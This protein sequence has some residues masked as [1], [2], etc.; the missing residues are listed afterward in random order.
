MMEY[1]YS[2]QLSPSSVETEGLCEGLSIRK[3]VVE[4][5]RAL[6][7]PLVHYKDSLGPE[8]SFMAVSMPEYLSD[9]FEIWSYANEFAFL[10]GS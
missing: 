8:H 9:R 10:H 5:W 7:A 6:V 2:H 1:R 3:H 4:D